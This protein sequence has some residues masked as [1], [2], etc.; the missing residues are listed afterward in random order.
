MTLTVNRLGMKFFY[1]S[2]KALQI[3]GGAA[4]KDEAAPCADWKGR[5]ARFYFYATKTKPYAG[6]LATVM[7]F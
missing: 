2:L 1:P 5:K 3:V 6:E 4:G 7:L